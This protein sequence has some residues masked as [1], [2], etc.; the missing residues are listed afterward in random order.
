MV[1]RVDLGPD[2]QAVGVTYVRG[3]IE[4][5]PRAR[6]VAIAGCSIETPRLL[7]N[8]ACTRFPDGLCN[9]HDLVGR[10]V[11]VQGAPQVAGRYDEVVRAYKAPDLHRGVLQDRPPEALP[12]G[13]LDPVRLPAA[14][15]VG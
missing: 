15:R 11:M 10:Y 1:T 12:T 6:V 5:R 13:L 8:S 14:D 3:G 9:D 7:L 4:R 2:G